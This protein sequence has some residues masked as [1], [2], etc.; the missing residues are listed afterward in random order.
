M[1][2]LYVISILWRKNSKNLIGFPS[3]WSYSTSRVGMYLLLPAGIAAAGTTIWWQAWWITALGLSP[4]GSLENCGTLFRAGI[5]IPLSQHRLSG[6]PDP[7]RSD[8]KGRAS[9][10]WAS[11]G[12][13]QI[14]LWQFQGIFVS[15]LTMV[16]LKLVT[17][18]I[19]VPWTS[20][21]GFHYSPFT[22]SRP[23]VQWQ[24]PATD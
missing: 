6:K 3:Y 22:L 20:A 8:T 17:L 15:C 24:W 18:S 21:N 16:K 4:T 13:I 12:K 2:I 5:S 19:C 9:R 11:W 23:V 14:E 1:N 7:Q 10:F